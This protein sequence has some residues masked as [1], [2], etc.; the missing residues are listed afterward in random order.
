MDGPTRVRVTSAFELI[1]A[2]RDQLRALL[3]RLEQ[4]ILCVDRSLR[5]EIANAGARTTVGP[6]LVEGGLLP[7]PWPDQVSLRELV[8]ALFAEGALGGE[9]HVVGGDDAA[10]AIVGLPAGKPGQSAVLLVTDVSSRERTERIEREFVANAS[11]ELRTPLA[12]ITGAVEILQSGAKEIPAVRDRFLG[13]IQREV[14]RLSKLVRA[15]LVLARAQAM[16]ETP[17]LAPVALRP[18]LEE[19]ARVV[20]AQPDVRVS[21]VCPVELAAQA[22]DDLLL[23][24]VANLATNAASHTA[25]GQ[26]TL[27]A[28]PEGRSVVI[29]VRDTGSG[30]DPAQHAHLFERF[31]RPGGRDSA[32]FGLGL[33]IVRDAVTAVGGEIELDS[34]PGEGTAVRV[35]L[36]AAR[37]VTT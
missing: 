31:Y 35:R 12:T 24:I 25:A 21:I 1:A 9:A 4:G 26:I 15:L 7:E 8:E 19:V 36:P 20:D 6:G 29:E 10:Y 27:T 3:D 32:R 22:D 13:H 23:E 5:V 11:H 34:T 18:L 2:E 16:T 30:I 17:R 33:A 37:R 28:A 14:D